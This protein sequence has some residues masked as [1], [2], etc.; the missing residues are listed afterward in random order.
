MIGP[1][2]SRLAANW[3]QFCP[4]QGPWPSRGSEE[5]SI[6]SGLLDILASGRLLP[7]RRALHAVQRRLHPQRQGPD[8]AG[9]R[10]RALRGGFHVLVGHLEDA[11]GPF[12]RGGDGAPLAAALGSLHLP[13][14]PPHLTGGRLHAVGRRL[15]ADRC[16]LLGAGGLSP[17]RR[18]LSPKG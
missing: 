15:H 12:A 6:S 7:P 3:R 10:L 1:P 2:G 13:G 8:A 4:G 5:G 18:G 17:G 11:R 9:G 14:R 16:R